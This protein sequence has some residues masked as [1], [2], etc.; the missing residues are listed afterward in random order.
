VASAVIVIQEATT[1]HKV[2]VVLKW[3]GQKTMVD[4]S[5][6]PHGMIQRMVLIWVAMEAVVE[7]L[8]N[9]MAV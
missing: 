4:V 5:K 6:L 3:I 2:V 9:F 8:L 7:F 1:T